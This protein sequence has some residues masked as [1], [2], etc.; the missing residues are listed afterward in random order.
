MAHSPM[1]IAID[2]PSGVGKSTVA[3]AVAERLGLPYVESGAMYRAVALLAL[4]TATPLAD[5]AALGAIAKRAEFRFES[6]AAGNRLWLDGRD[7][8]EAIRSEDVTHAASIVSTHAT[9]RTH[10]VERQRAL[11]AAGGVVMEG[12]D[13]GTVVFPDA[14]L[15]IFL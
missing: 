4:E 7:V 14:D 10:L 8:T 12:R 6:S 1:V 11:G 3:R 9:V 2:G 15:K 5:A 13:I